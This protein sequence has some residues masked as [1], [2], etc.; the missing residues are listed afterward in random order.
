MDRQL[1]SNELQVLKKYRLNGSNE[2]DSFPVAKLYD[3]TFVQHLLAN[4]AL[5]IGAPSLKVAGSIFIKR[6]AFLPVM[7]LYSMTVWNKSLNISLENITMEI[8]KEGEPWLPSFSLKE[9][10][11]RDWNGEDRDVWRASVMKDLFVNNIDPIITAIEKAVGISKSILWE[12]I[13][14]YLFWLYEK[15]LKENE[16]SN[17]ADDFRCLIFEAEGSLFG[18]YDINPLQRYYGEKRYEEESNEEIRLRKTC[19]FSYQLP[20]GKR[21]KICPC[22]HLGK[23]GRCNDGGESICSAVRSFG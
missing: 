9:L 12:N 3:E 2:G 5:T 21:C 13:V 16:N 15:E 20:E 6:Y 11:A 22:A 23:D 17:V 7:A 10:T 1:T 4:V 8:P 14:V 19:C 18:T